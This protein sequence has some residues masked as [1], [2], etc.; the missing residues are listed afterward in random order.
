MSIQ[1][2]DD[3]I[4]AMVADQQ[5]IPMDTQTA[6]DIADSDA[7]L[8]VQDQKVAVLGGVEEVFK[9]IKQG[10]KSADTLKDIAKQNANAIEIIK[11]EAAAA[12]KAAD[13]AERAKVL[14]DKPKAT[15]KE[16]DAQ[17]KDAGAQ[18]I[19]PAPISSTTTDIPVTDPLPAKIEPLVNDAAPV[20]QVDP[21]YGNP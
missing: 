15:K 5:S 6:G 18:P 17:P 11:E 21:W 12:K 7:S 20:D 13:A 10:I 2:L 14:K 16:A 4:T 19:E 3:R 8:P 1:Q 9:V